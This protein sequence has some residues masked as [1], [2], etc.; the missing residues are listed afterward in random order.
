LRQNFGG[1]V[2]AVHRRKVWGAGGS[3]TAALTA[4]LRETGC[5]PRDQLALVVVPERPGA[6]GS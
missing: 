2:V 5:P 6:P 3:H 4:A 1:K